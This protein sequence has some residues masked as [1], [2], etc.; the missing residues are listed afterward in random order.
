[1]QWEEFMNGYSG[2]RHS[3]KCSKKVFTPIAQNFGTAL[4]P[5]L[6]QE[7]QLVLVFHFSEH[8]VE[9]G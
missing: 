2:M 9:V 1:M 6:G 7:R 4:P 3:P 5:A 8:E